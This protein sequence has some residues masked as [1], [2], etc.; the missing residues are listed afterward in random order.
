MKR[1]QN[2]P[3]RPRR[4]RGRS[5]TH[6]KR[7]KQ[8]TILHGSHIPFMSGSA[9]SSGEPIED[10]RIDFEDGYGNRPDDEEDRHAAEV[11]DE[12]DRILTSGQKAPSLGIRVKPFSRDFYPRS[13]RT[14]DILLSE[15]VA[16]SH[17]NFPKHFYITL[18]KVTIPDE[19]AALAE[20]CSRLEKSLHLPTGALL[21]ELMVET[22]QSIL[23]E[24]GEANLLR[25]ASAAQ[26]RCVAMHFG[27]YDYTAGRNLTA[28][29]QHMLHFACDF[30]REL[31]QVALSGTGIWLSDGGTN[32]VPVPPNQTAETGPA[33]TPTQIVENRDAVHR[34][35]K[36]HYNHIR[37]SLANG[38]YQGWDLHPAQ[39]PV[40]TRRSSR[41]SR[42]PR[43]GFWPAAPFHESGRPGRTNRR[44]RC[45]R[46]GCSAISFGPSV[47][48]RLRW[49][50]RGPLQD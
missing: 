7:R 37:H 30:A 19:V 6:P 38:Y 20:V 22:T 40:A 8:R 3:P 9:G 43:D 13:I 27:T 23:N 29:Y 14:L 44:R 1:C 32:V 17:G 50:K 48:E 39:L 35:W 24:R 16:K 4:S 42:R 25:L 18:A 33:L 45:H 21:V 15:L 49:R 11:A 36:L 5:K 46:P 28:A 31:M 41:F 34:A 2:L 47:A 10:L 12:I 26:G